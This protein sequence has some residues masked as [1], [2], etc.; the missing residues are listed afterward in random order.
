MRGKGERD[1]NELQCENLITDYIPT[2]SSYITSSN[3]QDTIKDR[4]WKFCENIDKGLRW[5]ILFA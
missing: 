5:V 2:T 3:G 4:E 1:A